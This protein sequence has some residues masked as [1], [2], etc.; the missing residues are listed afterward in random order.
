LQ[1][2]I[3]EA[4]KHAGFELEQYGIQDRF[5]LCGCKRLP[6]INS[7]TV[8][9]STGMHGDEPAGPLALLAI[10][11]EG[12]LSFS[13]NFVLCPLLNPL[14]L[15]LG[16]RENPSG[17]DLNRD[18]LES[19][20]SEVKAHTAWLDKQPRFDLAI[21][22]H[23]DCDS[24]GFY[25]NDFVCNEES[26]SIAGTILTSVREIC[27][28]SDDSIIDDRPAQDGVACPWKDKRLKDH[29]T[30]CFYLRKNEAAFCFNFES[31]SRLP[32]RLRIE[33]QIGAV[34]SALDLVETPVK[35][36][37]WRGVS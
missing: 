19:A 26:A 4:C 24:S 12:F 36:V 2:A 34:K 11:E 37:D 10:L 18:Y 15:S 16:T 17:V 14:G 31:P 6:N 33:G 21:L 22:M 23:E 30:E 32:L 8:Y 35:N 5:P 13:I 25:L 3:R 7:P 29:W 20:T 9:I 28:V 1:G 27:P